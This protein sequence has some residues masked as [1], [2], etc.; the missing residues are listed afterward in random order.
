MPDSFGSLRWATHLEH[1]DFTAQCVFEIEDESAE[2]EDGPS[3]RELD[4]EVDIAI[5]SRVS[6]G[7]GTDQANVTCSV[8]RRD[9]E[10]FMSAVAEIGERQPTRCLAHD[11]PG[12]RK[13][14]EL[15]T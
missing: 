10:E 15:E 8:S 5:G 9:G 6:S 2:I 12:S 7:Y 11:E 1:I 4:K 13:H 3:R 14:L